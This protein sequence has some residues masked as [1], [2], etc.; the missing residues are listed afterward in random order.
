MK[1]D[2]RT[3]DIKVWTCSPIF[4]MRARFTHSAPA[5]RGVGP[6]A[7]LARR[8]RAAGRAGRRRGQVP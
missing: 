7:V 4:G 8:P 5:F 1:N 2:A 3:I 6:S